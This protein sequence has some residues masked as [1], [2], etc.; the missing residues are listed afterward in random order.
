[1]K[2]EDHNHVAGVNIKRK[3][4]NTFINEMSDTIKRTQKLAAS[5]F[6]K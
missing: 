4:N 3:K 6:K 2:I 5:G 1:M